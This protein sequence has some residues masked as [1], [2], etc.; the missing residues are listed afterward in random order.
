MI[1]I[2]RSLLGEEQLG[3]ALVRHL[4]YGRYV[5]RLDIIVFSRQGYKAHKISDRVYV[6]PTNSLSKLGYYFSAKKI[7][8]KIHQESQFELVV[9]QDPFLTG[10]AGYSLKKKFKVPLLLHCHGD[11]WDNSHWLKE[12]WFNRIFFSI[13]KKLIF[14]A[15]ALRVVTGQI[16]DKL[17]KLG[18]APEKIF[19]ISTPVDFQRF[20][21]ADAGEIEK[22]KKEYGG[23]KIILFVGR[24]VAAKDIP[25]LL[26]AMA[27]VKKT[28][29]DAVCLLV[30]DGPDKE[31]IKKMI[32]ESGLGQAVKLIGRIDTY[33]LPAYYHAAEFLV[34]PSTNESFGKVILEA[35]AAKKPT[36]STATTGASGIIKDNETGILVPIGDSQK[37]S[38]AILKLLNNESLIKQLGEAAF[39]DIDQR[40]GYQRNIDKIISLWQ[41]LATSK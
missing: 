12:Q 18:I 41:K 28:Y 22:I 21:K 14:K 32:S 37:L 11:F 9:C 1:S 30:G 35:A 39:A 27:I 7:G 36:V 8:E 17:V 6:W 40:F 38:E 20:K 34:L 29:S 25:N 2:D 33:D 10:L 24:L 31:G 4:D 15:D 3:D 23:K 16:K 13:G 19:V 5:E 26:S